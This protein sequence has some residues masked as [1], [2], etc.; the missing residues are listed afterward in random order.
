MGVNK[1]QNSND[2]IRADSTSVSR[3]PVYEHIPI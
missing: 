1:N 2:V 3:S